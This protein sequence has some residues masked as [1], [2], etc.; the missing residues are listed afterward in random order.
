MLQLVGSDPFLLPIHEL[1]GQA[2]DGW[3]LFQS[4][5]LKSAG[6]VLI[7]DL[8]TTAQSGWESFQSALCKSAT[9]YQSFSINGNISQHNTISFTELFNE[10]QP[11]VTLERQQSAVAELML[12]LDPEAALRIM[13]S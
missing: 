1:D 10:R 11:G 9:P 12:F 13:L 3:N 7:A 2:I 5:I 4:A 6:F 8:D